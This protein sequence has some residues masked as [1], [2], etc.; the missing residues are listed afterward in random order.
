MTAAEALGEAATRL[1]AAG[2]DEPRRE[3]RLLLTRATGLSTETVVL[4]PDGLLAETGLA[5][6]QR[7]VERRCRRE[8]ISRIFG[9]RE[10][11]S[12]DFRL[13]PATLDPRPDSETL[14]EAAL[15]HLPD[16]AGVRRVLDLGTGTGCLLLAALSEFRGALGI[17]IDRSP[18]AVATAWENA[19]RLGFGDR[20]AFLVADWASAIDG[21]FDLVLS[22]PPYIPSATIATLAPEVRL[23]DPQAA[24]DG[25]PDGLAAYRALA[26][27]MRRILTLSGI[28]VIELGAGQ[29]ADVASI[30]AASGLDVVERRRDLGGVERAFVGRRSEP[31][32]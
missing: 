11:W 29:A 6:F 24:L 8:P 14:I 23:H 16:R 28:A 17:G 26:E 30:F 10:F 32:K 20:V 21:R 1:R 2:I 31:Q 4:Q 15:A 22:N 13:G 27:N 3:A 5:D 25:G 7:A 9:H 12:L 19:N 18:A